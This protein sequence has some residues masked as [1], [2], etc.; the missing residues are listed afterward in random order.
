M[1]TPELPGAIC[2]TL[3]ENEK[4]WFFTEGGSLYKKAKAICQKCPV[5]TQCLDGAM[6]MEGQGIGVF[7]G[8]RYGV[9]GAKTGRERARLARGIA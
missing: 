3:P 9:W 6:E 4:D 8:T 7:E 2:P 1:T 5:K